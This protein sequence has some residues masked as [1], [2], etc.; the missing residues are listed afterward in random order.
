M[1]KLI[2]IL[3]GVI[4]V[5][6]LVSC[7]ENTEKPSGGE[8]INKQI[9]DQEETPDNNRDEQN[10]ESVN[11]TNEIPVSSTK[12]LAYYCCQVIKPV[13]PLSYTL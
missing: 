7:F 6:S 5:F 2:A 4:M 9:E 10:D 13:N 8:E 11:E 12:T 3:L 1:K